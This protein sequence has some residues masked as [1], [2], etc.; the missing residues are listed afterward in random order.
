[1]RF[2]IVKGKIH[3]V[4]MGKD[5]EKMLRPKRSLQS[6]SEIVL[7]NLVITG[8]VI[9]NVCFV[10]LPI[11]VAFVG[12]FHDWNPLNGTF[13]FSGI[14]NY[15]NVFESK[16]FWSSMLNTII[17]S[18]FAILFRVILGLGIA[19]LLYSNLIRGKKI[20]RAIFYLPT[21]TPLI[22]VAFVWK[23]MYHPQFGFINQVFGIHL[24][25]LQDKRVALFAVLVMTIWKD[26]GYAVILFLAGL[27][28]LPKDCFEAAEIAGANKW[29][30][31]WK[32]TVPLLKPN[33]L[34]V[35][36]TSLI[37]YLQSY[38]Q[39]MVMTEGGP[40]TSTYLSTYLVYKEAFEKYNFGY[41]SAISFIMFIII[42]FFSGI[43][44]K[45]SAMDE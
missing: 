12:S 38:V 43:S 15:K 3:I 40:G 26:F 39:I 42:A 29:N 37:T 32:I 36:V 1:M 45:V 16:L 14:E 33:T 30:I 20:F 22:A 7:R 35:V 24:N 2:T 23:L 6:R 28:S 17:F 34:F 25:W 19:I 4:N 5:G 8:L 11:I 21:V 41:A 18:G 27:Y 31:F 10:I 44:F 13:E 9:F